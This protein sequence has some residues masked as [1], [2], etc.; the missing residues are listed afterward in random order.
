MLRFRNHDDAAAALADRLLAEREIDGRAVVLAL[1]S[2][3]A[4]IAAR[5]ARDLGAALDAVAVVRLRVP[6]RPEVGMG[7]LTTGGVRVLRKSVLEAY[8]VEEEQVEA[9]VARARK[10]LQA[11]ERAWRGDRP[12]LRLLGRDVLLV[13]DAIVTGATMDAAALAARAEGARR[14]VGAAPIGSAEGIALVRP[15]VASLV[16]VREVEA[17]ASA[18]DAYQVR[19]VFGDVDVHRALAANEVFAGV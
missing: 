18:A 3:G 17:L 7:V 4:P 8:A 16:V 14:I 13:D 11:R 2:A 19:E 15:D 9:E 6:G 12:P 5:I 10:D 1:S